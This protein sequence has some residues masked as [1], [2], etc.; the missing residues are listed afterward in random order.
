M[1]NERDLIRVR[2]SEGRARA[3]ANG[4]KLGRKLTLTPHQQREAISRVLAGRETLGEIARSCNVHSRRD[5][6]HISTSTTVNI[7]IFLYICY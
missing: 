2:T 6:L 7:Y 5:H 3:V 1:Q 4:V